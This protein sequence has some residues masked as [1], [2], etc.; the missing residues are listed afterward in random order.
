MLLDGDING[1]DLPPRTL[2]LTYDDGPGPHTRELGEFL[3]REGVRAA[4][5]VM[6]RHAAADRETLRKLS[7]WGHLIGNHTYSHPG[8]LALVHSG[9][10]VVGE[11]ARTDALIREFVGTEFVLFRPPYGNWRAQ[12]RPGGP[13]DAPDSPVARLLR[14]SGRFADYVGPV[15]WDIVAEDWACWERGIAVRDCARSHL[16]AV[17]RAGRGILLLHDSSDDERLVAR[18][19]T[20]ELTVRLVPELKR[21][22]YRFVG[23]DEVPQVRAAARARP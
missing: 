23:L 21:R 4:F 8:L 2:C 7:G 3:F 20:A 18:N 12:T 9:G 19:R 17:G 15:K 13:E 6:G 22:G 10:D 14:A 16:G 1:Y 5:F 11:L